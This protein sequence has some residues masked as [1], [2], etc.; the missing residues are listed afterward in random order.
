MLRKFLSIS[1]ALASAPFFAAPAQAGDVGYFYDCAAGGDPTTLIQQAGHTPVILSSLADAELDKL[2][3]LVLEHCLWRPGGQ[4]SPVT[5]AIVEAVGNGMAL[6]YFDND[7]GDTSA[8]SLPLEQRGHGNLLQL[9]FEPHNNYLQ[10]L[11]PVANGPGGA[12]G[13]NSLR[14]AYG[15]IFGLPS[16]FTTLA[17]GNERIAALAYPYYQGKVAFNAMALGQ[18][19]PG[20]S[21]QNVD[22][23]A[24]MRAY[25]V[26][27][28]AWLLPPPPP[29]TTC[30][31]EGYTGA[32]LTWCKN[33]CESE[34]SA[35]QIETWLHRWINRYRTLP[36]CAVED[37][38]EP[39]LPQQ[40]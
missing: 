33:I 26:N 20:G 34:L 4:P 38:E 16:G 29:P 18:S 11:A 9:Q 14:G 13:G 23:A 6:L 15:F 30:A 36:Y 1:L 35:A 21:A 31:S 2:D 12:L 27:L 22:G 25:F 17:F 28:L 24:G 37:E 10:P 7:P 39:E 19:L 8:M 3:A 32:K 5:P 40:E